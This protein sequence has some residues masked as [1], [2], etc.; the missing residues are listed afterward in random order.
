MYDVRAYQPGDKERLR[1]LIREV[2]SDRPP[3]MFDRRWWW[4]CD[5]PPLF[6]AEEQATVAIVG[7]CAH[8]EFSL[9]SGGK[10]L[11]GAWLVDLFV[12]QKHQGKGLGRALAQTVMARFSVTASLLQSD[13]AWGAFRKIG[14]H[15]RHTAKLYLNPVVLIPGALRA[16]AAIRSTDHSLHVEQA[17][18]SAEPA[19]NPQLDDLWS[20]LCTRFEAL[21][22]RDAQRIQARYGVRPDRRYEILRAYR[23]GKLCAYMMVR[24]CPPRSLASLRRY[25]M[26]RVPLGLI[27]DY[28]VDPGEP[29]VFATLLDRAHRILLGQGARCFLCLSTVPAFHRELT[30][31]GYL[32]AGS[33]LLGRK[34]SSMDVGFTSYARP[35]LSDVAGRRWFLTLGDCDMDL[36]W[37]ESPAWAA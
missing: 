19:G 23:N 31:R 34:L 7:V 26:G 9:F 36:T 4:H 20:G 29:R 2:W 35:S 10:I 37:G 28:L 17:V 21:A 24:L 16:L 25:P 27:V 30:G 15:E 18:M 33:P 3:Q 32:H 11:D 6:V 12:A 22:V 14:W 13:A 1:H 8:R 5:S